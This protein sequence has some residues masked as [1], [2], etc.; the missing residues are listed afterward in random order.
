MKKQNGLSKHIIFEGMPKG[1][2]ARFITELK[3]SILKD[4]KRKQKLLDKMKNSKNVKGRS[5]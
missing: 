5:K 3:A 4:E 1:S 2:K